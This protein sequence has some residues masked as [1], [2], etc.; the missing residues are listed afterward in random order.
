MTV[1][2]LLTG[3]DHVT[4]AFPAPAVA[5]TSPGAVGVPTM[6]LFD[7]VPG[8]V[9]RAFTA[10][11]TKVYVVPLTNP[12]IG[13][14]VAAPANRRTGCGVVPMYGVTEYPVIP[15][16]LVAGAVHETVA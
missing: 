2:P 4:V 7:V 11:T 8:P 9:P 5:V 1:A 10:A 13:W 15:E 14:V 6:T 3:A 16:P 12:V